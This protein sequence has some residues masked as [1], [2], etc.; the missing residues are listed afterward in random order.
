MTT[1]SFPNITPASSTWELVTNTKTFRSPLTNA[2]QTANRKGSL[3]KCSLTFNNLQTGDRADL[4]AF[5]TKLNGQEHRFNLHDHAYTRRGTGGG[6]PL[7]NGG[8]QTGASIVLDGATA[9]VSNWLRAGDYLSFNNQLFMATSD[10]NSDGSG[11]V[12]VPIAPPIRTSPL[13]NTAVDIVAPISGVFMLASTPSWNNR[14]GI[15]S[16]FKVDAIED[17]LA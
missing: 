16:T 15:F 2:V 9:S 3:W 7:V 4:Q 14:P 8:S 5:L 17:V 11:N 10:V 12:T 6:T 13:D 1:Y